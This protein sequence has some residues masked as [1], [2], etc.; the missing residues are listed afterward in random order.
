MLYAF[1]FS[2]H[3]SFFLSF[4]PKEINKCKLLRFISPILDKN[5][6]EQCN[7]KNILCVFFFQ[8]IHHFPIPSWTKTSTFCRRFLSNYNIQEADLTLDDAFL[9]C[10]VYCIIPFI[11]LLFCLSMVVDIKLCFNITLQLLK[12]RSGWLVCK[13]ASGTWPISSWDWDQSGLFSLPIIH[14]TFCL[15]LFEDKKD[16]STTN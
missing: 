10:P 2:W 3:L 14:Q 13:K 8:T 5:W 15:S 4:F 16:F 11:Y 1:D 12:I 9:F 6:D 7:K